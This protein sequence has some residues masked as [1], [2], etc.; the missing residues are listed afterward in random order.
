MHP[1]LAGELYAL[2]VKD[3]IQVTLIKSLEE[4]LGQLGPRATGEGSRVEAGRTKFS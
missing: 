4:V 2:P 3:T 1:Q